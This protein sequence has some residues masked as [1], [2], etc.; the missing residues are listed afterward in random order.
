[1]RRQNIDKILEPEVHEQKQSLTGRNS[2]SA[3]CMGRSIM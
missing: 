3:I 1:M 2:H